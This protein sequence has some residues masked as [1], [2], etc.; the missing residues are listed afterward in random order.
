[1]RLNQP[2]RLFHR[3]P[4]LRNIPV[5]EVL[6]NGARKSLQVNCRVMIN[7]AMVWTGSRAIGRLKVPDELGWERI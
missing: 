1:M 7:R 5:R 2:T 3:K 6:R 4:M